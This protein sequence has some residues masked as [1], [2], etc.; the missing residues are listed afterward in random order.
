M[1]D[2]ESVDDVAVASRLAREKGITMIGMGLGLFTNRT[3]LLEMTGG[4]PSNVLNL[5]SYD[6]LDKI[7]EFISSYFC[8][9]IKYVGLNQQVNG[10]TVLVPN[11]PSYFMTEK[12][13]N[14]SWYQLFVYYEEDPVN[15]S[16]EI[17]LSEVDPFADLFTEDS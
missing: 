11:S 9:Q 15:S 8:R 7:V 2:G 4:D 17:Y 13:A 5:Q 14:G 6:D 3:Q 16:E 12:S 1:T 10:N